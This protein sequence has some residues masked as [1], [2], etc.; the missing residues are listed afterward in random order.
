MLLELKRLTIPP[1]QKV[2]LKD[3]SWQ[4]FEEIITDLGESRASRIA[5]ANNTLEII[6]P[7]P[8]HELSK[9][10]ISD[11]IKALLEELDRKF[12]TLGSTTFKNEQMAKG[13]E[14]D[15][16]FYI[17]NEAKVR[18]KER[19]DLTIDPPPDL[20]LEIY[21]TSRTHL[22]IY[23]NLGVGELWRFEKGKLQIY[24]LENNKYIESEISPNFPDLPLTEVIPEYS[25]RCQNMG[26]N[27]TMKT[28]R[29]WVREQ[30]IS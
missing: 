17:E 9:E 13:I 7:L 4:E 25:I 15:N 10:V 28:F 8:E 29:N 20:A 3:V 16:C 18:G 19:L 1:G 11:L 12:L 22:N 5:Y 23:A 27:Q 26:I 24:V 2:L 6:T 30:I 21:I 14:P